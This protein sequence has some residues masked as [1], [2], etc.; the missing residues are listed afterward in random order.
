MKT[1]T[2]WSGIKGQNQAFLKEIGESV[3]F[4]S[5]D[6]GQAEVGGLV[7]RQRIDHGR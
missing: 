5:F 6:F 7:N 2:M 3:C 1:M 4:V